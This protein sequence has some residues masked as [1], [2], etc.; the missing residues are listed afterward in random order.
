[1]NLITNAGC[2]QFVDDHISAIVSDSGSIIMT[3]GSIDSLCNSSQIQYSAGISNLGI[4][5]RYNDPI[6]IY[7]VSNTR[8]NFGEALINKGG[9]Y[10]I[11]MNSVPIESI[12]KVTS[13]SISN[14]QTAG[15]ASASASGNFCIRI[16]NNGKI[17][18]TSEFAEFSINLND[19]SGTGTELTD[20]ATATI[21]QI[22]KVVAL[23]P[24]NVITEVFGSYEVRAE[25]DSE[26]SECSGGEASALINFENIEIGIFGLEKHCILAN[27][28]IGIVNQGAL[29]YIKNE[30]NSGIQIMAS[31][32]PTSDA[33]LE[34]GQLWV[35]EIT[36]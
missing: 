14:E 33:N 25:A 7:S 4:G 17:I 16:I 26:S 11:R 31:G 24:G 21:P 5:V 13:N 28:G 20:T 34:S 6:N 15:R 8:V 10:S 2:I 27:D 3:D 30:N 19:D 36:Y 18:Y 1:M 32:L 12:I 35:N 29:F 23:S 9:V 22:N